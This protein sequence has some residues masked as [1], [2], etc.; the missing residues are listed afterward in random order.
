MPHWF[1]RVVGQQRRR[2]SNYSSDRVSLAVA[3]PVV[4]PKRQARPFGGCVN[5]LPPTGRFV[6]LSAL[7]CA[8][9]CGA[10]RV[11]VRVFVALIDEAED[12]CSV[13]SMTMTS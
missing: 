5:E 11:R 13:F 12:I 8:V 4:T 1:K 7:C 10:V 9:L 2:G 3:V 6:S